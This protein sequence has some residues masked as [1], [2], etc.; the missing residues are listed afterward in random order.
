[1]TEEQNSLPIKNPQDNVVGF[2]DAQTISRKDGF[3][4]TINMVD[5]QPQTAAN[6]GIFFIAWHPI[7]VLSIQEVHGTKAGAAA[8]VTVEKLTATTAKGSGTS[9]ITTA[10]DLT[11]ADNTVQTREALDFDT[12]T[13]PSVR[14]LLRGDR[15]ALKSTGTISAVK[16]LQ[17]TLYCKFLGRGDYR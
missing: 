12:T 13:I 17:I 9:L 11:V 1:M 8:T 15:L 4:I 3:H 7:E 6:Y 16:D 2:R 5:T 10:F 14:Q